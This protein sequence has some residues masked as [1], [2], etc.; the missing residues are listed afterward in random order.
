[1]HHTAV[2]WGRWNTHQEQYD[3]SDGWEWFLRDETPEAGKGILVLCYTETLPNTVITIAHNIY[4]NACYSEGNYVLVYQ[5]SRI[6]Y[7]FKI[8]IIFKE[9]KDLTPI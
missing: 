8:I 3:R 5:F 6:V 4:N 9:Q 1:M 7:L 2:G